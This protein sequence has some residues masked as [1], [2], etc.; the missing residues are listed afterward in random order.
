MDPDGNVLG[1]DHT[2]LVT[3][4]KSLGYKHFGFNKNFEG[5][6][7]RYTYRLDLSISEDQLFQNFHPTTKKILKRGNPY[8]FEIYKN[9]DAKI[10]DFYFTM[11]ETEKKKAS[12]IIPSI[13][14]ETFMSLFIQK[15][16]RIY[17]SSN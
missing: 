11:K 6:E 17:T 3:F 2:E 10:E 9:E 8:Q 14:I 7:P 5:S 16:C 4:L 15:I 13:I 12:Y 1:G